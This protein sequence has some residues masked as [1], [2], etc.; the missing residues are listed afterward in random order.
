VI[1]KSESLKGENI[2]FLNEKDFEKRLK[3]NP[4][5]KNMVINKKY[6]NTLEIEVVEKKGLYYVKQEQE[7]KYNVV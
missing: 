2:L 4:Y 3:E 7:Y 6:P 1:E 5:I